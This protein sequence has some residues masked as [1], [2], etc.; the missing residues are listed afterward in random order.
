VASLALST[1]TSDEA[2]SGPDHTAVATDVNNLAMVLKDLGDLAGARQGFER[3]L[4]IGEAAYGPDHPTVATDVNNLASVLKD[5]G[6][7]AGAR[8]GF[9]RPR[10]PRGRLRTRPPRRRHRRP[11]HPTVARDV[12]NLAGVL[13]DLGDLAGARQGFERALAIDEA[14]YGPDHPH[15]VTIAK[16]LRSLPSTR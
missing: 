14:A 6:D 9:A 4:A 13:Q 5:L 1:D 16:N 10:H 7:L 8:Q 2:T 3:A 11:D 15:T 12:N